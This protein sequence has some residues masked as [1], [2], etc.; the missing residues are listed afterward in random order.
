MYAVW[1]TGETELYNLTADPYELYPISANSS[2]EAARLTTRM[3][4]LM[5]LL[6]SC[7][8]QGCRAPWTV[9]HPEGT[10]K[11][12]AEALHP[13][14]DAFYAAL[15]SV[16]FDVCATEYLLANEYPFFRSNF[17]VTLEELTTPHQDAADYGA[18][19]V[20]ST[21]D[22]I[23]WNGTFFG[24]VYEDLATME[25]RARDLTPA[26]LDYQGT[27]EERIVRGYM[28]QY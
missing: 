23:G 2:A 16:A 6:K 4:G 27:S 13:Q 17:S 7:I 15:P 21:S 18:G 26:E 20:A 8:G 1:C 11:S 19:S 12:L 25:A 3:N 9:L 28:D 14:F 10:V 22:T 5:L 24:A